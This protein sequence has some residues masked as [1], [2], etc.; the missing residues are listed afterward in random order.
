MDNMGYT[1]I[2]YQIAILVILSLCGVIAFR[3]GI[4][5]EGARDVIEKLVF[6]MTLP[7]MIFTKLAGIEINA[8]IIR[9]GLLVILFAYVIM[10]IQIGIGRLS[11]R[12]QRLP[13]PQAAIHTLHTSLGNIVFLGFPLLD[14]LFPGGEAILYAALY[15]L[16]SNT[17]LWSLGVFIL[18]KNQKP[19]G[20]Q[21]LR[22][23]I[24]PNTIALSL[25][26][27]F[28]VLHLRLPALIN[29]SLGGLGQTTLFL[30]MLYI[31]ILLAQSNIIKTFTRV[32]V[33][34]LSFNKL[35]FTPILFTGMLLLVTHVMG[36]DLN[37]I[38]FSVLILQ[39]AMPCMT[40]LVIVAKR[41]GADDVLAMENFAVTTVLGLLT[42]PL[43]LF[44]LHLASSIN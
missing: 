44:I 31:G 26:L 34:I 12:L 21:S 6:Y 17:I 41:F 2:L 25:G 8:M 27:V 1:S 30:A 42:L 40:I 16:V 23:L 43:I 3:T 33:L 4:V 14:V 28:M 20:W 11:S 9:N 24:N 7:L 13:G 37:S 22:K 35:I 15:Q 32:S 38:A 39:S 19:K 5:K 10:F 18:D 29:D 36:L